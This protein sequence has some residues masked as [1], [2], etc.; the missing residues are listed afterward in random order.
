MTQQPDDSHSFPRIPTNCIHP[1]EALA[2]Y[3]SALVRLS[4][5]CLCVSSPLSS[6][7][8]LLP[9]TLPPFIYR[10]PVLAKYILPHAE[11]TPLL[12][13]S[14]C[15]FPSFRWLGSA[16]RGKTTPALAVSGSSALFCVP[17]L[18]SLPVGGE[19]SRRLSASH[20][21]FLV[22][23]SS[24]A[25]PTTSPPP[26]AGGLERNVAAREESH[27]ALE[28][29]A[30]GQAPVG[31]SSPRSGPERDDSRTE[32]APHCEEEVEAE[33]EEETETEDEDEDRRR[34]ETLSLFCP[35]FPAIA[36]TA[37]LRQWRT[38]RP[39]T[40]ANST[41]PF[42]PAP[43]LPFV[44]KESVDCRAVFVSSLSTPKRRVVA[45]PLPSCI[46]S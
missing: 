41:L 22:L 14:T 4:L 18:L 5:V 32:E 37:T 12:V 17:F 8:F 35:R 20:A 36:F 26:A 46:R 45:L 3:L 29:E 31:R 2:T 43:L 19:S 16:P 13:A 6:S 39:E 7:A 10:G 15:P 34:Q 23:L 1:C 38:F 28:R 25:C 24:L 11:A 21:P 9:R 33:D 40:L 27:M 30:R 42:C 44:S